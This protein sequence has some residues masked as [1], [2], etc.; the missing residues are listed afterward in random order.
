IPN[1][2]AAPDGISPIYVLCAHNKIYPL[3]NI[4]AIR[5]ASQTAA[6][7]QLKSDIKKYIRDPKEGIITDIFL[8]DANRKLMYKSK[9]LE[10]FSLELIDRNNTPILVLDP[11][12]EAGIPIDV[13]EDRTSKFFR[14]MSQID[15][16]KYYL[17]FY[18][19]SDSFDA[20]L[21]MRATVNQLGL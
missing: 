1:P 14:A 18:V 10:L 20:Y 15:P 4:D 16:R 8:P 5:K 17:M 12:E 13:V 7:N 2:R 9:D 19:R 3:S 6:E 21:S 11:I